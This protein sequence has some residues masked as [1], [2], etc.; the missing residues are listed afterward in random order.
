MFRRLG[1]LILAAILCLT[2]CE[3]TE[4]AANH[5]P[6]APWGASIEEIS[7]HYDL[8]YV[9]WTAEELTQPHGEEL[10][11]FR[12]YTA[13][14]RMFGYPTDLYFIFACP[15]N[16]NGE[17]NSYLFSATVFISHIYKEDGLA[18]ESDRRGN[19]F[20]KFGGAAMTYDNVLTAEQLKNWYHNMEIFP[21]IGAFKPDERIYLYYQLDP[22]LDSYDL[23]IQTFARGVYSKIRIEIPE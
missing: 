8:T 15:Q 3:K 12:Q 19:L 16:E 5:F 14:K 20:E 18:I 23:R 4:T 13:N 17:Y 11:K 1:V 21:G 22:Y 10:L 6:D 9:E 2:G 7:K